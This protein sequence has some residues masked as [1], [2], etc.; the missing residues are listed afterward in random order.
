[1]HGP[2]GGQGAARELMR[3]KNACEG[4]R[5]RGD[6]SR[7]RKGKRRDG[8]GATDGTEVARGLSR[9][10][11]GFTVRLAVW[12]HKP[13]GDQPAG[14]A[15]LEDEGL[16]IARRAESRRGQ[17]SGMHGAEEDLQHQG[18]ERHKGRHPLPLQAVHMSVAASHRLQ[19]IGRL[20][21]GVLDRD[22]DTPAPRIRA[23]TVTGTIEARK[24]AAVNA[25]ASII[26]ASIMQERRC[27]IDENGMMKCRRVTGCPVGRER[28]LVERGVLTMA[29]DGR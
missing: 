10:G 8:R 20:A 19:P 27:G 7:R 4:L 25:G 21:I 3:D 17:G 22:Q 14:R 6:R 26:G 2:P 23:A 13:D 28:P 9:A 1:V 24:T 16:R 11:G 15:D 29:A 5:R 18:I 12:F